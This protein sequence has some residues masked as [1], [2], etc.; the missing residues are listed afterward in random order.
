[1][2]QSVDDSVG[3]IV[4]KLKE[5]D[6]DQNTAIIFMSDNGGLST[7]EGKPTSNIPLR[8]GKGWIYEGGIRE[9]M[10]VVWPGV[11]KPGSICEEPV[12]SND[13]YPTM[14][15]MA[16]LPLE[17]DQHVDGVSFAALLKGNNTLDR[18]AI[19]WHYPHYGN[20]GG[21]PSAAVRSGE[22]KLIEHFEDG[23]V[24]LYDLK[25]D[26]GE[27]NDLAKA[28]PEKVKEMKTMLHEW[29]KSVDARMP[30][31]NPNYKQQP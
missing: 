14:L 1:M 2:I 24:E 19:F 18:K 21:F 30:K 10:F 29:Q 3:R 13:F 11:V 27:Q 12:I 31:P 6:L 17:Y 8:A 20:Q 9:P 25:N 23:S 15:D 7:S 26:I 4:T 28:M 16:G 5:L 22:F